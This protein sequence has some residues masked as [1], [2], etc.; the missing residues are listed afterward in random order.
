MAEPLRIGVIGAGMAAAHHL[1]GWCALPDARVVALADTDPA[2]A[3]A[4]AERF[5]VPAVHGSAEA[6]LAAGGLD[7]VD[8][9][10]PVASHAGLC[11]LAAAHG[12]PAMCQK[13]LCATVDEAARLVID[14]AGRIRLKVHENWRF[15]PEWRAVHDLLAGEAVGE[16]SRVNLACR[17]SGL[18]PAA[19]GRLPALV[20]QP[21]LAGLPRLIVFELLVHHLD[22][23]GWLFGPL[24]L[25]DAC[26]S[27]RS[28]AVAGED[29]ALISLAARGGLEIVLAGSFAEPG[30]AQLPEDDL[31]VTGSAGTITFRA[32]TLAVTGP[33]AGVRSYPFARSYPASYRD[34]IADFV[35]ALRTG[36]P[37]ETPPAEHLATLALVESIYARAGAITPATSGEGSPQPLIAR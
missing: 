7:A 21:F 8:I 16:V 6:M 18:L 33:R 26:L 30:A 36:R 14:V 2:R 13:P 23:L 27:R 4:L 9:V 3:R 25:R 35:D 29:T 19:D 37:F 34:T 22:V 5:E 28:P 20:R 1:E 15:R 17:S 10:T 11:R 32:G 24:R 12:L 31:E